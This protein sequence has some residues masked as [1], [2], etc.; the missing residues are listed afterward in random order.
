MASSVI[1]ELRAVRIRQSEARNSACIMQHWFST[2][3]FSSFTPAVA[4]SRGMMSDHCTGGVHTP[5]HV[6]AKPC[7]IVEDNIVV[8]SRFI[9][10]AARSLC[11]A[12]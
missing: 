1:I 2:F 4:R 6:L 9:G 7:S 5:V 10:L 3:A 8:Y 12:P 11:L